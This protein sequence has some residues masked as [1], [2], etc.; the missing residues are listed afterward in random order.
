MNQTVQRVALALIL[1]LALVALVLLS[2]G[3]SDV[4]LSTTWRDFFA[5]AGDS[6]SDSN[7]AQAANEVDLGNVPGTLLQAMGFSIMILVP[8]VLVLILVSEQMRKALLRDLR[9]FVTAALVILAFY[10]LRDEL[11]DMLSGEWRFGEAA[12]PLPGIPAFIERP[13]LLLSF[14]L[15]VLLLSLAVLVAWLLWR[16]FRPKDR[17]HLLALDAQETLADL[18]AG[19]DFRNTII[20][21]YYRMCWLLATEKRIERAQGMTP[22]EFARKVERLGLAGMEAQRLTRL[23]ERVRYGGYDL[24]EADE[25][26]AMA[27]LTAVAQAADSE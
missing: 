2:A 27:C 12:E 21:H 24:N 17:L 8:L 22:R 3:L 1:G 14:G 11:K 20:Q 18:E 23:F 19:A 7:D 16:R 13:S 10:L 26:E 6:N 9:R 25:L 15:S 4:Q 5:N